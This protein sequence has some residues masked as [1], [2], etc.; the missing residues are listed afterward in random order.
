MRTRVLCRY[1]IALALVLSA[2]CASDVWYKK[3]AGTTALAQDKAACNAEVAQ[4]GGAKAKDAFEQCMSARDWYHLARGRSAPAPAARKVARVQP[5]EAAPAPAAVPPQSA[6]VQPAPVPAAPAAQAEPSAPVVENA[7]AAQ[8]APAAEVDVASP[9]PVPTPESDA[10]EAPPV[11][12]GAEP[13][14]DAEAEA[15]VD[16]EE[17]ALEEEVEEEELAP[18]PIDPKSRQFWVK[19]GGGP[20]QLEA[21]Q[22]RC[23]RELGVADGETQPSRWGQ[24]EEFDACMRGRGWG[25]GSV[26]AV[27][28]R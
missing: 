1:A 8:S 22:K 23:R 14:V 26:S 27:P 12:A 21:D 28:N 16:A 18:E 9:P 7:P 6:L 24:S 17:L 13:V 2:G 5:R 20:G 11:D 25:G 15:E 4:L 10:L 3:G 19:L